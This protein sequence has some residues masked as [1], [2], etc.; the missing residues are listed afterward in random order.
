M[1]EGVDRQG[2]KREG[3]RETVLCDRLCCVV[4]RGKKSMYR[5]NAER[6]WEEKGLNVPNQSNE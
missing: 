3:K 4:C 6:G 1:S 2:K 5:V